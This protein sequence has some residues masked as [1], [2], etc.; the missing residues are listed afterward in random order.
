MSDMEQRQDGTGRAQLPEAIRE[1]MQEHILGAQ[2]DGM[3]LGIRL[4]SKTL[5]DIADK[6]AQDPRIAADYIRGLRDAS[7]FIDDFAENAVAEAQA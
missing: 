3:K 7:A 4:C 2:H 5:R 6:C 1:L